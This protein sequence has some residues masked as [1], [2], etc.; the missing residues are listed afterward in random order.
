MGGPI[1][2]SNFGLFSTSSYRDMTLSYGF[3]GRVQTTNYVAVVI[4]PLQ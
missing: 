2:F 4:A 3:L 1:E